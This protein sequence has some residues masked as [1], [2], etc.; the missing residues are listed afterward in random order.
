MYSGGIGSWG[1]AWRV[2]NR[3]PETKPVLLFADTLIE[4]ADLYRFLEEGAAALGCELIKITEGRTP[5]EVFRDVRFLGNTRVD[6]CSRVLKREPLRRWL[7]TNCDPGDT[8]VHLGMDYTEIHRYERAQPHWKPWMIAAP[9]CEPPY[10]SKRDIAAALS[11]FGIAPP[12]LYALGFPHNN[13]GGGCVKAGQGHFAR[14]L[15][16]LPAVYDEW[17][18]NEEALR[19]ELGDVAILRD[20]TGGE[21]RPLPLRDLRERISTAPHTIDMFDIG[22]CACFEEPSA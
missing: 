15:R 7:E 4:D 22:G 6:P 17:E 9:L 16:K 11:E 2:L 20:R 21:T 3:Y 8:I 18:R 10:P 19:G 5:W 14:L 1:A 13:C 12:R